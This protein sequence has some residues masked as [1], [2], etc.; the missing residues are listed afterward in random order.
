VRI[1]GIKAMQ[2]R[3]WTV[4]LF[5]GRGYTLT[6]ALLCTKSFN[7]EKLMLEE[8]RD[9][10]SVDLDNVG[11]VDIIRG[12]FIVQDLEGETIFEEPIRDFHGAALKGCDECADF[13]G[14]RGGHLGRERRERRRLLEHRRPHR[15]R[16]RGVRLRPAEIG[17]ARA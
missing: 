16:R 13:H 7:Y 14:P 6:I 15:R 3:P 12:K 5:Q 8:I 2:A 1:E 10:R 17:D 11:R 9:K 4:G